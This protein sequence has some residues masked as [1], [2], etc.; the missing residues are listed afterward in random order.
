MNLKII[1]K[2]PQ[3]CIGHWE[4]R[5]SLV[6][7]VTVWHYNTLPSQ[8]ASVVKF[9]PTAQGCSVS[10]IALSHSLP[11][12]RRQEALS[13][14]VQSGFHL[15]L[16]I[17]WCYRCFSTVF[18]PLHLL[19]YMLYFM[20]CY[21]PTLYTELSCRQPDQPVMQIII[22]LEY[23]AAFEIRV[24]KSISMINKTCKGFVATCKKISGS[25]MFPVDFWA[26]VLRGRFD[27][28]NHGVYSCWLHTEKQAYL[29][30]H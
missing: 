11:E 7:P 21:R 20:L 28:R 15:H 25:L 22:P 17:C 2:K 14:H 30:I 9:A 26:E 5:V 3:K 8:N 12:G 4:K 18:A 19:E 29:V 16:K 13:I 6:I 1:S 10:V 27:S 23:K 24:F